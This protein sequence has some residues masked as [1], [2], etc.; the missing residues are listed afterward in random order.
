[1][2]INAPF[3]H[4]MT[5]FLMAK[6]YDQFVK[7]YPSRALESFYPIKYAGSGTEKFEFG[8]K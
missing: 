7:N 6:E 2:W 8:K 3:L 5:F 4:R 1:M